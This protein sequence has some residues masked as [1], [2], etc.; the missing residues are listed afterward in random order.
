MSKPDNFSSEYC[1]IMYSQSRFFRLYIRQCYMELIAL[2]N[3]QSDI[4]MFRNTDNRVY[5]LQVR[6]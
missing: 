4:A 1:N 5:T 6:T 3:N 2:V